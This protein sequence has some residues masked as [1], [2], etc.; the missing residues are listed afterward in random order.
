MPSPPFSTSVRTMRVS[1]A[2]SRSAPLRPH[3][4][5]VTRPVQDV[6]LNPN[7]RRGRARRG[8]PV[9]ASGS[10]TRFCNGLVSPRS[11]RTKPDYALSRYLPLMYPLTRTAS[12]RAS[13]PQPTTPVHAPMPSGSPLDLRLAQGAP[14]NVGGR[15]RED[16][17]FVAGLAKCPSLI[18][19]QPRPTA[20]NP[21]VTIE[22]V[23][24][25]RV[26]LEGIREPGRALG[27]N[28][29]PRLPFLDSRAARIARKRP[30]LF[31]LLRGVGRLRAG[32][33][34][35]RSPHAI[36]TPI[37]VSIRPGL[38]RSDR[39]GRL[40]GLT[41]SA[42]SNRTHPSE[43]TRP[44]L[45]RRLRPGRELPLRPLMGISS[46]RLGRPQGKPCVSP[47]A[48]FEPSHPCVTP[49]FANR[50]LRARETTLAQVPRGS[51]TRC[52]MTR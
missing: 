46:S 35:V 40:D 28:T 32:P 41:S 19:D 36:D 42:R 52:A 51:P 23:R 34:G 37:L 44:P 13:V 24:I 5:P 29:M 16:N 30:A 48:S 27:T 20:V 11:L 43:S 12:G 10:Y 45:W 38:M 18:D 33:G 6:P 2:F 26:G 25:A 3:P 39:R 1:R 15:S 50:P 9:S 22:S 7:A 21:A 17:P 31:P 47:G 4:P 8:D 49:E 14:A